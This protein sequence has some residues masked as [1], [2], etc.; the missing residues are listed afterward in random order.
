M[1]N[2][3]IGKDG[4]DENGEMWG[5]FFIV[6]RCFC[7]FAVVQVIGSVFIQN[8]FKVAS[9]D[10]DVMI[11]E[12]QKASEAYLKHLGNLFTDLDES[13]DG[14]ISKE[15]FEAALLQPRI[16][17]WFAALEIDVS[18]L[19]KLFMMLDDGD[20]QISKEEFLGG[21]KKVKGPAL[22]IDM[23]ALTKEVQRVSKHINFHST[24]K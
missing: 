10:E 14:Q 7:G 12:K 11:Q 24:T 18:D 16:R 19:P 3:W 20:G 2:L 15:E 17:H 22:S 6:W 4:R 5:Y 1:S 8:T 23:L 9:R 21:L 13:G